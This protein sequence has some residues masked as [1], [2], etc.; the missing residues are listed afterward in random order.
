M[1]RALSL[2]FLALAV[3]GSALAASEPVSPTIAPAER[4]HGAVGQ[5]LEPGANSFTA[6]QVR[7]RL[8]EMGFPEVADLHLD[9]QGIW[10]GRAQHVGR[11]L[12]VGMDYRGEVAAE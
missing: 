8:A 1:M 2:L 11:T 3:P 4:A 9:G 10:R 12:S 6:A 5:R 7:A